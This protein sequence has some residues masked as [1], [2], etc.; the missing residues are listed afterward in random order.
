[1]AKAKSN[2]LANLDDQK[3]KEFYRDF[4][5]GHTD[6]YSDPHILDGDCRKNLD[7]LSLGCG[8]GSD[9]WHLASD[10]QVYGIDISET[11]IAIARAHGIDAIVR[12]VTEPF[13]YPDS[14][15]DIVVAKDILEHILNPLSVMKEIKRVIRPEGHLVVL[16]PNQFYWVFRL[17]YLFGRNLIWKTFLHDQTKTFE[18]WNYIHVRFFTWRGAQRLLNAAGFKIIRHYFDFGTLEHYFSPDRYA[19]MYRQKWASGE[20]KSKRGLLVCYLIFPL[21]RFFN[22]VFP[23]PMRNKVVACAPGLLTAAFYLRCTS[24]LISDHP[25]VD[26]T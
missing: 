10:H 22:V 1:M 15:F 7:I 17:R 9:I 8:T 2:T 24:S 14:S 12:S 26:S 25:G 11:G 6:S 4:W 20:K 21:W 16:I 3:Q 18:E 19:Q 13:P 5:G 23:K